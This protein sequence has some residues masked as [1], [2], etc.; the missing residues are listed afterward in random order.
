M[1][2]ILTKCKR[3]VTKPSRK[4]SD[5]PMGVSMLTLSGFRICKMSSGQ[6]PSTTLVR[7]KPTG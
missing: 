7:R 3:N 1:A 6:L 5:L 2:T 4:T